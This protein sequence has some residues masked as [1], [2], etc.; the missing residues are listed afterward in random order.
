M[1]E[2]ANW[3][4]TKETGDI[5]KNLVGY[6][7]SIEAIPFN[8]VS[9]A[10]LRKVVGH[11]ETLRHAREMIDAS[12]GRQYSEIGGLAFLRKNG[13]GQPEHIEL[14]LVPGMDEV[15][16]KKFAD[17]R[18]D[19]NLAIALMADNPDKFWFIQ[20]EYDVALRELR[21]P[22]PLEV[23]RR[24]LAVFI[25]F[26]LFVNR[27]TYEPSYPYFVQLVGSGLEGTYIAG[28]HVHP[29]DNL[30]SAEDKLLAL[31][32]RMLVLVPRERGFDFYDLYP[33][34]GN[35]DEPEIIS[36]RSAEWTY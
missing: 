2:Y 25:E 4:L 5:L 29:L 28:F 7:E 24:R 26:Y 15:F 14:H 35:L 12:K 3:K 18:N 33:G 11:P 17:T 13:A 21:K 10:V 19:M 22:F 1:A 31:T 23:K 30:P 16:V 6:Y 8:E 32:K 9:P 20:D 34:V 27:M 36:Y